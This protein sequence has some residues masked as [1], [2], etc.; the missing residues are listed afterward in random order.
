MSAT[1][2][3]AML[4]ISTA[5]NSFQSLHDCTAGDVLRRARI[6][7]GNRMATLAHVNR[8][9]DERSTSRQR[10]TSLVRMQFDKSKSS[11]SVFDDTAYAY[12]EVSGFTDSDGAE[13][14]DGM[15][16]ESDTN[17]S[18]CQH[19]TADSSACTSRKNSEAWERCRA[20]PAGSPAISI[21]NPASRRSSSQRLLNGSTPGPSPADTKACTDEHVSEDLLLKCTVR[22][23]DPAVEGSGNSGAGNHSQL[24]AIAPSM[25]AAAWAE[26]APAGSDSAAQASGNTSRDSESPAAFGRSA[27]CDACYNSAVNTLPGSALATLLANSSQTSWRSGVKRVSA[28]GTALPSLRFSSP[29]LAIGTC[30]SGGEAGTGLKQRPRAAAGGGGAAAVLPR[31]VLQATAPAA[32][33]ATY[34]QLSPSKSCLI[35][36]DQA[37]HVSGGYLGLTKVLPAGM[38]SPS[39]TSSVSPSVSPQQLQPSPVGLQE[40]QLAC[41]QHQAAVLPPRASHP[42]SNSAAA[43]LPLIAAFTDSAAPTGAH[44]ASPS[45][46]PRPAR[47]ASPSHGSSQEIGITGGVASV[48]RIAAPATSRDPRDVTPN[49]RSSGTGAS[50]PST[51]LSTSWSGGSW[52]Y[53]PSSSCSNKGASEEN[54]IVCRSGAAFSS[55]H[56]RPQGAGPGYSRTGPLLRPPLKELSSTP[57]AGPAANTSDYAGTSPRPANAPATPAH[58][59]PQSPLTQQP[60]LGRRSLTLMASPRTAATGEAEAQGPPTFPLQPSLVHHHS[61]L[62]PNQQQQRQVQV[63]NG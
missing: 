23:R 62:L 13:H 15:S 51:V 8:V 48:W 57:T 31:P 46:I 42:S 43:T 20:Q 1:T 56:Q 59:P 22:F 45:P 33:T 44:A 34:L 47:G 41:A 24:R 9:V 40:Q 30:E 52:P 55:R 3:N 16:S 54:L 49:G 53:R 11:F 2:G 18:G 25:L 6:A 29:S 17:E 26:E 35:P 19:S 37:S 10:R 5:A 60:P 14:S 28:S 12:A 4:Q 61:S 7:H 27:A 21:G 39:S 50:S 36:L 63:R 58:P 38:V 32:A